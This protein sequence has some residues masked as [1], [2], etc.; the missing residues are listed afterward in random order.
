MIQAQQSSHAKSK[1]A[2]RAYLCSLRLPAKAVTLMYC[3][4][5]DHPIKSALCLMSNSQAILKL[6]QRN[7]IFYATS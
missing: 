4:C 3:H 7:N 1:A 6:L 5:Q 2:A